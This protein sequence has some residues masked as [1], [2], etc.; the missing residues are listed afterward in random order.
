MLKQSVR[1]PKR[2]K[3]ISRFLKQQYG[4]SWKDIASKL[5]S[6]L[7]EDME[8]VPCNLCGQTNHV[9]VARKDKFGLAL[10]TVIC[11]H[12]GLLYLNP[13]PTAA[14]Y[15]DFY[16]GGGSAGS[17]YH[18]QFDFD[19]VEALL[20]IYFGDDFTMDDEARSALTA[21]REAPEASNLKSL[22]DRL[23]EAEINNETDVKLLGIDY[24]ARHIYDLLKDHVPRGGRVFEPG[25][26][27]GT[28][29]VPWKV[30]HACEISGVEPKAETVRIVKDRLGIELFQGFAD[31][32]RIPSEAYDLVINIRTINHMLDPLGDLRHA[33]RWLKKDG[34][35]F[36]DI[37]DA[38]LE[39]R[40]DGFDR[41]VV[42]IDHPYMFSLNTLSAMVQKA[43]F[44]IV[45][46]NIAELQ[47]LRDWDNRPPQFKQIRIIARKSLEPVTVD[48]PEPLQ[49]LAA[50][51]RSE[52][53]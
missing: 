25:A 30:L 34:I 44:Q 46:R 32:P 53:A 51:L 11:S 14:R 28:M 1:P 15:Q 39:A 20:K 24:Y 40:Y 10:T 27:W 16:E 5:R 47:S 13:R 43:G 50:L 37:Q 18:R 41:S 35:L 6:Q 26:S 38:T 48:W 42:E 7:L 19:Q 29:L 12:C 22:Q 33:W 4:I 52:L 45:D 31:D 2:A 36:V 23:A 8:A 17:I 9:E 3:L 49:E 21:Y